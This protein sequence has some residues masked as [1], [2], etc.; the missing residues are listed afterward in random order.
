MPSVSLFKPRY[1]T[2]GQLKVSKNWHMKW[3][4]DG[5]KQSQTTGTSNKS[6]A[7]AIANAKE[8]ELALA[9][10]GLAPAPKQKV[11][12]EDA[13]AAFLAY[14]KSQRVADGTLVAYQNCL[15]AFERVM[16]P[17]YIKSIDQST[18]DE[19]AKQRQVTST[20]AGRPNLLPSPATVN[21][22]MVHVRAFLNWCRKQGHTQV[23]IVVNKIKTQKT[24]P[25]F[26]TKEE[27]KRM[28]AVLAS[29]EA[30]VTFRSADWWSNYLKVILWKGCRREA[31]LALT[32]KDVDFEQGTISFYEQKTDQH[33][34][35]DLGKLAPVLRVWWE[36]SGRPKPND[37]VFPWSRKTLRGFY[38]DFYR[39]LDAAKVERFN[40]HKLRATTTTDLINEFQ[41]QIVV[42]DFIG[43]ACIQTTMN[44]YANTS[45]AVR[46]VALNR[47][48]EG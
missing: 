33:S 40:P 29:D 7:K 36:L 13:V 6:A 10:H 23:S 41:N 21:K 34:T 24:P 45:A 39:I 1:T 44:H 9:P 19:Y 3:Q 30:K 14:Q 25:R 17:I 27:R 18:L 32:W 22:E 8:Q 42:K 15:Q 12:W 37:P 35:F 47:E 11:L 46:K 43:H 38:N 28:F 2:N 26:V 48:V 5:K 31:M 20:D 4:I 16:Q